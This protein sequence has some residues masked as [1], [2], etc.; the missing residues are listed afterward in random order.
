[1]SFSVS[2]NEIALNSLAT[3]KANETGKFNLFCR[4]VCWELVLGIDATNFY[5]CK[6]LLCAFV[7][8]LSRRVRALFLSF[9]FKTNTDFSS[10]LINGPK[11]TNDLNSKIIRYVGYALSKILR[12]YRKVD[13]ITSKGFE[14][15]DVDAIVEFLE[16][17][18]LLH[19]QALEGSV[20]CSLY[21]DEAQRI[22]N[23]GGLVLISADFI[24]FAKLLIEKIEIN[25]CEQKIVSLGCDAYNVALSKLKD[26]AELMVSFSLSCKKLKTVTLPERLQQSLL[27]EFISRTLNC[28]TNACI[29]ILNDTNKNKASQTKLR[30]QLKA[31]LKNPGAD[32]KRKSKSCK[33]KKNDDSVKTN[34]DMDDDDIVTRT[35]SN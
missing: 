20:Y 14:I 3:M 10:Q 5:M 22:R 25:M 21:Y 15:E 29:T 17:M 4:Q 35:S 12:K 2:D 7:L 8:C 32:N 33:M 27:F 1:M 11:V 34:L 19:E 31:M 16:N 26:D 28:I 13:R 30:E 23:R 18:R 9:S 6:P 24:D